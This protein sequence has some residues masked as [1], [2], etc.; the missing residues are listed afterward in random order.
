MRP[1]LE[2]CVCLLVAD[3]WWLVALRRHHIG[4]SLFSQSWRSVPWIFVYAC[5]QKI[6]T[7]NAKGRAV[8]K[9]ANASRGGSEVKSLLTEMTDWMTGWQR[10]NHKQISHT[11]LAGD[12]GAKLM[13]T[14]K[15]TARQQMRGAPAGYATLSVLRSLASARQ[16]QSASPS[17]ASFSFVLAWL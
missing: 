9:C 4:D 14:F 5:G 7:H 13:Q 12:G 6:N 8:R 11:Q 16:P 2:T 15:D 1:D 17:W 3:G 10:H